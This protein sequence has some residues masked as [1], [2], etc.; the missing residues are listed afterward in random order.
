MEEVLEEKDLFVASPAR[1]ARARRGRQGEHRFAM[2]PSDFQ[3]TICVYLR[4]IG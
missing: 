1:R 4:I 2:Q 3:K